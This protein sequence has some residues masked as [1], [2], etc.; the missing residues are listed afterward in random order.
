MLTGGHNECNFDVNAGSAMTRGGKRKQSSFESF[1]MTMSCD[2]GHVTPT[3]T[4][5]TSENLG[6]GGQMPK[7]GMDARGRPQGC[8]G[9]RKGHCQFVGVT[10]A[11]SRSKSNM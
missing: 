2:P 5:T 4:D 7:G 3:W 6:V 9:G 8:D 11:V 1:Y 10:V